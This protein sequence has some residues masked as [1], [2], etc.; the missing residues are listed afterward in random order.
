MI[1]EN[2]QLSVNGV[3]IP[4]GMRAEVAKGKYEQEVRDFQFHRYEFVYTAGEL[5]NREHSLDAT[6]V[7]IDSSG[8]YV[9]YHDPQSR[10][11]FDFDPSGD[12]LARNGVVIRQCVPED[13]FPV[14]LRSVPDFEG[15]LKITFKVGYPTTVYNLCKNITQAGIPGF[16]SAILYAQWP[17]RVCPPPVGVI[18]GLTKEDK[19]LIK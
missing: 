1:V 11:L 13:Q 2:V 16:M 18:V 6:G 10:S 14:P 12:R 7:A 9:F 17:G 3:V 8:N 19:V 4:F 15:Y 5:Y